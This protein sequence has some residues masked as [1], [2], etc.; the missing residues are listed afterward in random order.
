ML[1]YFSLNMV[2]DMCHAWGN[3]KIHTNFL[4]EELQFNEH[5]VIFWNYSG[6]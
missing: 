1:F 3:R 4:L 5:Y 6:F 2:L